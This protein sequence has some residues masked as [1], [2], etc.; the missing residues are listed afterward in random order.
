MRSMIKL[1]YLFSIVAMLSSCGFV[2]RESGFVE[3]DWSKLP[4]NRAPRALELVAW[5]EPK[6]SVGS[7]CDGTNY[8]AFVGSLYRPASVCNPQSFLAIDLYVPYDS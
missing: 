2:V 8:T 1:M 6:V 3:T 7:S 5:K 4:D